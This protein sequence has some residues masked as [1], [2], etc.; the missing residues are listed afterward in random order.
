[1]K[2]RRK[3][4]G[5]THPEDTG[6]SPF[7]RGRG[8]TLIELLVVI[9]IIALAI[10]VVLP[11]VAAMFTTA[12]DTQSRGIIS[13]MLGAARGLAVEN[14]SY[15]LLHVQ[16]G[17]DGACWVAVMR[18]DS[19]TGLFVPSEGYSPRQMPGGI[20]FG[21][22]SSKFVQGGDYISD[23]LDSDEELRDFTTFNVIFTSSGALAPSDYTPQI[24]TDV[25]IFGG[26]GATSEQ[27][28]W[29]TPADLTINEP[30]IRAMTIFPYRTLE[31][32][33]DRG[34]WLNE[35]GQFLCIN[36]YTGKLIST[37]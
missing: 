7:D 20:A 31:A 21:E 24:D 3:I 17:T 8:F 26:D 14:Q 13:A 10:S 23:A 12:S 35:N 33:N 2:K 15:C 27:Q 5:T 19:E 16:I 32:V 34:A 36:P 22:I 18:Y 28:I 4:I 37:K 30:T 25:K 6:S 1:M 29:D 9:S 11:P